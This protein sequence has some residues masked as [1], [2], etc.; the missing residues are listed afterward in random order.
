V[1]QAGTPEVAVYDTTEE[2]DVLMGL[3]LGC[4]GVVRVFLERISF[5]R[6]AWVARLSGK[7]KARAEAPVAVVYGG[8]PAHQL[9]TFD[10]DAP[11]RLPADAQIFR[12]VLCPPPA[13]T[14]F[15][16]GDDAIPLVRLAKVAGWHVTLADSRSAFA[17]PERFPEADA[18]VVSPPESLDEY[19]EL[20]AASFVVVMTHRYEEDVKLLRI[21]LSRRLA[22][23][24]LLG[25]RKRGDR[26]LAQLRSEGAVAE[27]GT[28][29]R[30]F[31]PVGLDRGGET[32]QAIALS[33]LAEM[34]CVLAGRPA[35]P[36]RERNSPIHA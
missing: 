26:I 7:L 21:L 19:L 25:P 22:Y 16:A 9:G 6:P 11:Q 4:R 33:I 17:S 29:E 12:E 15:G 27:P 34:Q 31:A 24:G 28:L 35:T 20:D 2:A 18:I 13:V 23:L 8:A 5:P 14:V 32:P 1:L 30:L 10:R 36:L 3:G